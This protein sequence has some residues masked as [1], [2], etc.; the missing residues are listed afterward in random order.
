MEIFL[1]TRIYN[2]KVNKYYTCTTKMASKQGYFS[3]ISQKCHP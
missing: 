1:K 2:K 3:F